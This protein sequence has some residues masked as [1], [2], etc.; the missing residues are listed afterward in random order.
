MTFLSPRQVLPILLWEG[1]A[2]QLSHN[3]PNH[4]FKLTGMDASPTEQQTNIKMLWLITHHFTNLFSSPISFLDIDMVMGDVQYGHKTL[5]KK[6]LFRHYSHIWFEAA[7]RHT[8]LST[9]PSISLLS[10]VSL[11]YVSFTGCESNLKIKLFFP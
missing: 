7:Y 5:P 8:L 2:P 1:N 3:V 10:I 9:L 11:F 6:L 4:L